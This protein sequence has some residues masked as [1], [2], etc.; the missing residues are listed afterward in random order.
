ME[1]SSTFEV[2]NNLPKNELPP[3]LTFKQSL[4]YHEETEGSATNSGTRIVIALTGSGGTQANPFF[5]AVNTIAITTNDTA[6]IKG[7][8]NLGT[9]VVKLEM[10]MAMV[11]R[12]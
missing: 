10:V 8:T 7:F 3:I 6:H 12:I 5:F 4:A 11:I 2:H 1:M 9:S